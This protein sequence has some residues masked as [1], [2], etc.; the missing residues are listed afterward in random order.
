MRKSATK[1]DSLLVTEDAPQVNNIDGGRLR[2]GSSNIVTD[3]ERE[4][5]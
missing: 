5:Y 1:I 2:K 4:A 3:G